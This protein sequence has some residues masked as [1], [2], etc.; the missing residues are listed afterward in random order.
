[1]SRPTRAIV[2]LE[3]LRH[4]YGIAVEL[5][6]AGKAL[7]VVK[8][9]AYGHGSIEV[10]KALEPLTPA[11]GVACIEEAVELRDAGVQKPIL[12]M[13]GFFSDEELEVAAGQNFWL[14]VQND[15]HLRALEQA[16]LT[17]PVSC[18]VKL[19]TGMHRLGYDP[20]RAIEVYE[21]LKGCSQVADDIVMAT[22]LASADDLDK[23]Y[24]AEQIRLFREH[25]AGI[26]APCSIAN[27]P[28]L[29]GWPDARAD[30]NRPGVMLYGQSPFPLPHPEA[31][32]LRP[33][34]TFRSAVMAVRE[35]AVGESVGYANAWTAQR[36]SRIATVPVGYGDGYPRHAENS[37]PVLINKQR[38]QLVG[39]VSM[40]MITLDV[41]DIP[42]ADI[43][44]EVILWG[45]DLKANEVAVHA[46]TI[47]Y[48]IMTRMHNR[49]PREYVG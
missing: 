34:M 6:G 18:W 9:N 4:N 20:E 27:S 37:T 30:W 42:T 14:M 7:P 45:E 17:Q 22:H 43:G 33:V 35:V 23:D 47:G 44:D 24:S 49:V 26:D 36:P 8:A 41:T 16:R 11:M 12:L 46:D 2:N 32:R 3:A 38:A 21:R 31:D 5:S 48:E 10:A 13:E 19:D 40:D 25:T 1:M 28:G 29:L 15:Y 39:R